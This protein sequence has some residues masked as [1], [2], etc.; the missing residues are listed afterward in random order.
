[1]RRKGQTTWGTGGEALTQSLREE[2]LKEKMAVNIPHL[3]KDTFS[4]S[5]S[6]RRCKHDKQ[7][8]SASETKGAR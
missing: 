5:R 2:I 3:M 1:M 8:P 4:D 7:K 6:T